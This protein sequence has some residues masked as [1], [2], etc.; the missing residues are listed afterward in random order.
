MAADS[1]PRRVS[2]SSS[3]TREWA[4]RASRRRPASRAP[5]G[6]GGLCRLELLDAT[7]RVRGKAPGR[8]PLHHLRGPARGLGADRGLDLGR[9]RRVLAQ[10]VAHVLATLTETLIAIRHP[11]PALLQD[12][13]LKRG[14]DERALT[15]D[16]LVE[17]DV[18]LGRAER[19]R[20]LV[21]HHL[22][23]HPGSN[24]VEARLDHLDLA[25]VEAHRRAELE[26]AAARLRLR[27]AEHDPDLLAQL[28]QE[29]D[30]A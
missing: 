19:R 29:D 22:D 12:P 2:L 30:R 8:S 18:E 7:G 9:K 23:L 21:L 28:A 1:E 13:V 5:T 14:V 16:A 11:R 17:Q 24:R 20:D 25:D 15:R 3:S 6:G 26:G 4:R 10:V 27:V